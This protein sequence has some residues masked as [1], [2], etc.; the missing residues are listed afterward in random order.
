[1]SETSPFV[2]RGVYGA[3]PAGEL[4]SVYDLP[5]GWSEFLE[6][7]GEVGVNEQTRAILDAEKYSPLQSEQ[8]VPALLEQ[9]RLKKDS[10]QELGLQ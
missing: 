1:L 10:M 4:Q 5:E 8:G 6:S 3:E 2:A 9:L 7:E